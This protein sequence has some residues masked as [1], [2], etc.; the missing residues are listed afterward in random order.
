MKTPPAKPEEVD[1]ALKSD[2][3]GRL[4]SILVLN[5]YDDCISEYRGI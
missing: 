5:N 3:F 4:M 1:L 2:A